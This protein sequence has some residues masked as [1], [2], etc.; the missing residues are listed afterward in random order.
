MIIE[1]NHNDRFRHAP[2]PEAAQVMEISGSVENKRGQ[3]R[4][5]F[6]I[7]ALDQ[8]RGGGETQARSPR[9]RIKLRQR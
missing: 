3:E 9:A 8:A 2:E 6:M 1:R 4:L 7:E 5:V